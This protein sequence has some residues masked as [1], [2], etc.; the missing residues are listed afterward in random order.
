MLLQLLML[1]GSW[2]LSRIKVK[3]EILPTRFQG[4][5]L[6]LFGTDNFSHACM[7][8]F[9]QIEVDDVLCMRPLIVMLTRQWSQM[10][11]VSNCIGICT[12]ASDTG[13]HRCLH[14][15]CQ[16]FSK[17]LVSPIISTEWAMFNS[18]I[19]HSFESFCVN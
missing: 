4:F 6:A 11:A 7:S 12:H 8:S 15:S 18:S 14:F 13:A 17:Q 19:N 3:G 10:T 2:C 1:W 16:Y 5:A 9:K